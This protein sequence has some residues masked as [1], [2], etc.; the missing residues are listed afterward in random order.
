MTRTDAP[1]RVRQPPA[2][3]GQADTKHEKQNGVF[4]MLRSPSSER[5]GGERHRKHRYHFRLSPT[6]HRPLAS[7]LCE[8]FPA[9]SHE[10]AFT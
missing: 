2:S 5:E 6:L 10:H 9:G 8:P 7:P 4:F 1:S 3:V